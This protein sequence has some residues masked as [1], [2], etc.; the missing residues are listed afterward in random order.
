[1]HWTRLTKRKKTNIKGNGNTHEVTCALS[2]VS[3]VFKTYLLLYEIS[4]EDILKICSTFS[5]KHQIMVS[6]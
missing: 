5:K 2:M 4:V 3:E 6:T 1:M